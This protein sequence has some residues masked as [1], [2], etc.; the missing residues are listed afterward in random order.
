CSTVFTI[1]SSGSTPAGNYPVTITATGGG[2]KKSTTFTLSVAFALTVAT[3]TITPNGGTFS[4]SVAVTL[5]STTA[6]NS[7]YYT[8]DGS[9]PTQNATLYTGTMTVTSNT[10]V[11]AAAFKSGYNPSAVAAATFTN[12]ITNT[13]G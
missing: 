3:P 5:L 4:S 9:A 6:G 12:S 7:I 11:K 8:T 10:T 1:S 2:L 13:S